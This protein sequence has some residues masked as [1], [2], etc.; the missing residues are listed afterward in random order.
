[1]EAFLALLGKG[2]FWKRF[3]LIEKGLNFAISNFNNICRTLFLPF[4]RITRSVTPR[5][6]EKLRQPVPYI[7]NLKLDLNFG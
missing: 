6:L 7:Y 5:K 1:M 4:Q 2:Q 3:T